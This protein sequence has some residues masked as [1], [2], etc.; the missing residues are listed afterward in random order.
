MRIFIDE[1]GT[2]VPS[3]GW[4]VVCSLALPS[5]EVGPTRREI[6]NLTKDWPRREGEL[7]GGQLHAIT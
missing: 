7:K 2:F 5:R 4:G 1:G 3:T 6:D